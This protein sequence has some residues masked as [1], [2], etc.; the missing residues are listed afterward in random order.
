MENKTSI[1][2]EIP[3]NKPKR[4]TAYAGPTDRMIA[5]AALLDAGMDRKQV[6]QQ[7]GYA[8]SY[9]KSMSRRIKEKG[10]DEY[11]TEKRLKSAKNVVDTFMQGK[12]IGRKTGKDETGNAI[13]LEPGILPKDSTIKDCAMSV[14]DR[15][16]PK[17]Q[18]TSTQHISF[19]QINLGVLNPHTTC[20]EKDIINNN[21]IVVDVLDSK[22][23]EVTI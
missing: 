9:A 16:Y 12:P 6:A 3:Q 20:S 11:V 22:T 21:V 10:V 1:Q 23:D 13:V 17:A 19:T 5:A 7:L 4:P 14:L 15:A 2:Q 18:E 8:P